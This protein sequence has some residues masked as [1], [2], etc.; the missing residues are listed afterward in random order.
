MR[1]GDPP[2]EGRQLQHSIY[3][4]LLLFEPTAGRTFS[5]RTTGLNVL[6][7]G[8]PN[9]PSAAVRRPRR[10]ERSEQVL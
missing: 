3:G 1:I 4:P 6:R 5:V 7:L 2:G 9:T 8:P 10:R